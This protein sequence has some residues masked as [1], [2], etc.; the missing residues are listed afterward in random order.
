[1][2]GLPKCIRLKKTF[3]NNF[4]IVILNSFYF[5][6]MELWYLMLTFLLWEYYA[7]KQIPSK[8]V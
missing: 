5:T 1:M 2:V 6:S 3:K 7:L 4:Q 8:Y